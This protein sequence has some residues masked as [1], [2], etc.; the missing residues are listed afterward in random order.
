MYVFSIVF[1]I[2]AAV[3]AAVLILIGIWVMVD[4][5]CATMNRK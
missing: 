5:E 2:A 3:A 4:T 1:M